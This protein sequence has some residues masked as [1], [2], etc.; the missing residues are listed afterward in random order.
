[1]VGFLTIQIPL[2][3]V[4]TMLLLWGS[5]ASAAGACI[6]CSPLPKTTLAD[7]LLKSKT[8]VMA[9]ERTDKPHSFYVVEVLKGAI[10]GSDINASFIDTTAR[11]MLMQ[12]SNGVIVFRQHRWAP[13]WLYTAYA[14]T[15][16]QGFIRSIL[17]QSSSWQK[18]RG[19][20][21]RIDFFAER[22]THSNQFIREQAYLEVGRA[23]YASIKRIAGTIPSQ[24]L[25]KFIDK[26]RLVEWHNL[27]IPTRTSRNH[28]G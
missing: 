18:F 11:R 25:R 12:N 8:V 9:R 5:F 24:Q 17:E 7:S 15:E 23:P 4:L 13:G 10:D 28:T 14:D 6:I 21:N 1:M 19:N 22:L 3:F 20:R 27:Y 2:W 16:Y 26:R